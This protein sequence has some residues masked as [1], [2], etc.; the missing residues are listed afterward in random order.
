MMNEYSNCLKCQITKH[1]SSHCNE[2]F[3]DGLQ[4]NT[5]FSFMR[6]R[7]SIIIVDIQDRYLSHISNLKLQNVQ[8]QFIYHFMPQTDNQEH[9]S[10]DSPNSFF[11]TI[12][13]STVCRA[14][15]TSGSSKS[16]NVRDSEQVQLSAS[17]FEQIM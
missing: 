13:E 15:T 12:C 11:R 3:I 7:L 17:L 6:C 4:L 9:F 8:N 10:P 1:L 2:K 16:K 14:D 5:R